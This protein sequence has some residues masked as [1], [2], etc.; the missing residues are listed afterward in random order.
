MTRRAGGPGRR[1]LTNT[2]SC[3]PP[4]PRTRRIASDIAFTPTVKA[5]QARKGSRSAYARME[6]GQGWNTT[7]TPELAAFI[8]AQTSVFLGT[9]NAAGQPYIQH[10]GGPPG[11]LRVL[12]ERTHRLRGSSRQPAIHHA[13]QSRRES[14]GTPVPDRLRQSA[15]DQALGRGAR[16]RGRRRAAGRPDAEGR[17]VARRAG[18]RFSEC[19]RGTPTAPST[20]RS[21]STRWTS[22]ERSSSATSASPNSKRKSPDCRTSRLNRRPRRTAANCCDPGTRSTS[23]PGRCER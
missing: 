23:G 22:R 15:A 12:D 8:A 7:I 16:R 1:R 21:A 19:W 5:I 11:F 6:G 14:Q 18:P 10:R 3:R 9:A 20:F 13:G 2:G 17:Q 4:C